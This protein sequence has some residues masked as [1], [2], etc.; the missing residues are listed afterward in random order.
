MEEI[1]EVN[2]VINE[3]N[4]ANI[5]FREKPIFEKNITFRKNPIFRKNKHVRIYPM[6]K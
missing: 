6:I 4:E 1:R 2:Y 3:T 5:T